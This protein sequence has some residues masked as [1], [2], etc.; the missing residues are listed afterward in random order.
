MYSY[1]KY[2]WVVF[3]LAAISHMLF[4]LPDISASVLAAALTDDKP[5]VN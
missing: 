3:L 4:T 1:K 5:M 2:V